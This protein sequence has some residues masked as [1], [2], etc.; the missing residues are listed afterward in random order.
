MVFAI[1]GEGAS[2]LLVG[3]FRDNRKGLG[4]EKIF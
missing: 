3:M 2:G 4:A 1:K